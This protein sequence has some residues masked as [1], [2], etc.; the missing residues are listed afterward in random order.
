[1]LPFLRTAKINTF[2]IETSRF[3]GFAILRLFRCVPI[4]NTHSILL[5]SWSIGFHSPNP[6]ERV[7]LIR[8]LDFHEF[9]KSV[10]Q[11]HGILDL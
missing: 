3:A 7:I 1:M 10:D 2:K 9:S 6:A 8:Y 4:E 11:P 5:V